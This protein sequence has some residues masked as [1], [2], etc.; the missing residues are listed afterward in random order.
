[1]IFIGF[2]VIC[3][4]LSLWGFWDLVMYKSW[5]QLKKKPDEIS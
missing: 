4:I 1:M 5:K 3:V 2:C